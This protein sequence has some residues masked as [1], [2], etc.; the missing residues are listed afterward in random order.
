M[1]CN[2]YCN[3]T[4]LTTPKLQSDMVTIAMENLVTKKALALVC[5]QCIFSVVFLL[6]SLKVFLLSLFATVLHSVV[7]CISH[8]ML[9]WYS[10]GCT[11]GAEFFAVS[12]AVRVSERDFM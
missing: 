6:L 5:D 9:Q 2:S 1:L 8:F 4:N 12:G 11:I 3:P 7:S 10:C